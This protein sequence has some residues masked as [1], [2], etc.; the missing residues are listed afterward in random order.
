MSDP[1]LVLLPSSRSRGAVPIIPVSA[2][3]WPATERNLN[4]TARTW[5]K[6]SGFTGAV[7]K[8]A[9]VPDQAGKLDKVFYAIADAAR[10][11]DPFDL[12]RLSR[13]LPAADY[14]IEGE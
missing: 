14:R 10:P 8:H 5:L 13:V 11:G 6:A 2:Q 12:A 9:L 7:G 4:K 3:S 1:S